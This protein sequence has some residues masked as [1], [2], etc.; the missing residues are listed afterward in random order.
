MVFNSLSYAIFLPIVFILYWTLPHKYRWILL[1]FFSYYFYMNWN[2]KYIVLILFVTVFSYI[3]ARLI[4]VKGKINVKK[5]ILIVALLVCIGILFFYKYFGFFTQNIVAFL[6][7]FFMHIS[8]ITWNPILPMGI[9]FYT[10]QA[11]SYVIDVYKGDINAEHH[12]G[13]Y[14]TY[15]AYFPQLVAGP[16]EKAGDLLP[17]IK[18]EHYFDYDRSTYGLK[19]MV[20]GFFK[21]IVVADRLAKYVDVVYNA[22]F[23]YRGFSFILATLMF[24][25]QIYC[26]F[27]GYSDIA[28][29]TSDLLG[30]KL[31]K[32]FNSPYFSDS[33]KDFWRKWHISLS[34][35]LRDYIYIPLGGVKRVRYAVP[36]I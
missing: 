25:I 26:D 20:W 18:K 6:E 28:I 30:I 29:G 32:N 9:S 1:L 4:E 34:I 17:Q 2:P 8:F 24:S 10:F 3:A 21:K 22:P 36:S 27:S 11:L 35:W 33:I 15:I 16:I 7:K 14:A 23:Q 5:I 13:K 19:L 12:F 31:M